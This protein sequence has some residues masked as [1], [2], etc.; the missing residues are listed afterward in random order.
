M[1]VRSFIRKLR[2]PALDKPKFEK[3]ITKV[4]LPKFTERVA[5]IPRKVNIIGIKESY[6][7]ITTRYL[8]KEY[9]M[10]KAL[11]K[12]D[13]SIHQLRYYVLE[14]TLTKSQ[15]RIVYQ[16]LEQLKESLDIELG[17]L[18]Q[19]K[20]VRA[21]LDSLINKIWTKMGVKPDISAFLNM[22]YYI[23]RETLGLGKIE[24][25]M[26]DPYI[27]DI[28]C[29]G[30]NLPIF[31]YHRNPLYGEMPTNLKFSTKEELDAYVIKLAQK[32]GRTVSV[33]SPLLDAALP[34]GSRV[35]ITFGTDI[36]RKGSNFSI[37]KFFKEPMTPI[38]LIKFGTANSIM[39]AY[40]WLAIEEQASVL[41]AGSTAAGKTTFLNCISQFIKP[42]LK[43]VSIEDTP[44]LRLPHL[45]WISQIARTGFGPEKY[46]EVS[47]FD[48]LKAALRQRPDYLIVGEVRGREADVLFHAM[49]TGH[50]SLST[51]HADDIEAVITR[52]TTRPIS[53]PLSALAQLDIIVFLE[54]IKREGILMR[55]VSKIV[56]VT[57]YDSEKNKLDFNLVFEWEPISDRFI[58]HESFFLGKIARSR[59]S[60][61][62]EIRQE[63]LRRARLLEW[64]ANK[65]IHKFKDVAN[66]IYTYYTNP[67]ELNRLMQNDNKNSFNFEFRRMG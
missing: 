25:L 62:L 19:K 48:L 10:A 41:I 54:K 40:L 34:D 2:K 55:K 5:F 51:I 14:P 46:G 20:E 31:V 49:A 42:S 66:Y 18:K 23:F 61:I 3:Q 53:L 67:T 38:D 50:P 60:S 12:Y 45:N 59:G 1:T 65:N 33:A 37:R 13:P 16:T 22:K 35:Q 26:H 47:M 36:S 30:V 39:L 7:L 52:L 24:P 32:C 6:E 29:D 58:P 44:E 43:I 64:L 17:K 4:P 9:V 15:Q 11:I 8:G 28:S 57:R 56:E 63:L 21:Y 27:E